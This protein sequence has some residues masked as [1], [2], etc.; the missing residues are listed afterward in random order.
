MIDE[1]G[2]ERGIMSSITLEKIKK[3]EPDTDINYRNSYMYHLDFR[4]TSTSV[5]IN[6]KKVLVAQNAT[7]MH[8]LNPGCDFHSHTNCLRN[9]RLQS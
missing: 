2:S 7:R 9:T 6:T 3:Q 5:V 8:F 1:R 4:S